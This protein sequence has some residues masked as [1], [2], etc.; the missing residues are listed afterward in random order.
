MA[1]ASRRG[2]GTADAGGIALPK[3][4]LKVTD[5]WGDEIVLTEEDVARIDA[6]RGDTIGRY[7]AEIRGTLADPDVVYEGRYED[8][9]VFYGRDR[10]P[11]DSRFRGCYVA[12]IVRY[13]TKPASVRT[14]Y[15][16]FNISGALGRLLFLRRKG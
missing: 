7:L 5:Q 6:K 13:S 15:F 4:V 10:L 2:D 8:S 3:I 16:P 1:S 12:V 9:K 11:D 14:V